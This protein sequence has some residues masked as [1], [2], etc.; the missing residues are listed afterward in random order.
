MSVHPFPPLHHWLLLEQCPKRYLGYSIPW[1]L[2]L[3][4]LPLWPGPNSHTSYTKCIPLSPTSICQFHLSKESFGPSRAQ[5]FLYLLS[6]SN[7]TLK[8][9]PI[10]YAF[11]SLTFRAAWTNGSGWIAFKALTKADRKLPARQLYLLHKFV[12]VTQHFSVWGAEIWAD[13]S[14]GLKQYGSDRGASDYVTVSAG[15]QNDH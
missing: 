8:T 14:K 11:V 4:W 10:T 12:S 6:Q 15:L 1:L 13:W 3:G 5:V 2:P 9:E 7:I